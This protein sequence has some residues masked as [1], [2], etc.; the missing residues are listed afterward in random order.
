M[1]EAA[2]NTI[3]ELARL[4]PA[5]KSSRAVTF[6]DKAKEIIAG[7]AAFGSDTKDAV[8]KAVAEV[9][10]EFD[11]FKETH[12]GLSTE[13]ETA[14]SK[15]QDSERLLAEA[16]QNV[17]SLTEANAQL[18]SAN[19]SLFRQVSSLQSELAS[20]NAR[21]SEAEAQIKAAADPTVVPATA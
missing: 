11:A 21:V 7:I 3:D 20:A 14:N 1:T 19:A 9:R 15:L 10:A 2:N 4:V 16:R 13:L 17:E 5:D 18:S 12:A 6:A 8:E